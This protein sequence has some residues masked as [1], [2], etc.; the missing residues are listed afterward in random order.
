MSYK[1]EF[2]SNNAD[3]Q[4]ILDAVNALPAG[5]IATCT[6]TV[7]NNSDDSITLYPMYEGSSG[8]IEV[9]RYGSTSITMPKQSAV[10]FSGWVPL[11]ASVNP[12]TAGSTKVGSCTYEGMFAMYADGTVTIRND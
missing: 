2:Q 6:V 4:A 12:S 8:S 9:D 1:T 5:G 11:G 3:L 10:W 7:V